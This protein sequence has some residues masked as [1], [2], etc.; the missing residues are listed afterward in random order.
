MGFSG[1]DY[2]DGQA[3]VKLG[4]KDDAWP[5]H[6]EG[7]QA[8]IRYGTTLGNGTRFVQVIPGPKSA[9]KLKENAIIPVKETSTPTEFDQMFN[10]FDA[11][12]R[13]HL[14]SMLSNTARTFAG[15]SVALGQGLEKSGPALAQTGGLLDDLATDEAALTGLVSSGHRATATLA[16]RKPEIAD[17]MTVMSKTF[18]A[19]AVNAQNIRTSLD[20][21]APTLRTTQGTLAR[22]DTSVD[23]LDGMVRDLK[24][25]AEALPGFVHSAQ[26]AVDQLA[27]VAPVATKTVKT[28]NQGA[29][30]ITQLLKVG[31][32]PFSRQLASAMT[33]FAPAV[34]C[35]RPYAPDIAGFFSNWSSWPEHYDSVS[36]YGRVHYTG[37]TAVQYS[38]TP[39]ISTDLFL[40]TLGR[41][42]HYAMPAPPGLYEGH[43]YFRPSAARGPDAL[44]PAKDPEDR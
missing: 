41:G 18:D 4:I 25:G 21:F 15:R 33:G 20:R 36:H 32:Q 34:A 35:I 40:K 28:I 5:L 26:P 19:F 42:L 16:A 7:T 29:A 6:H 37:P 39:P 22:L 31:G 30:D 12:T 17:L 11:K 43:P 10:T 13:V 2:E 27:D 3:I 38:D 9:P 24:P 44:N 14:K 8:A 1:H 23:K